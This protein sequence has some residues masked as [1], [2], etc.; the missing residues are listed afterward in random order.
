MAWGA[1]DSELSAEQPLG[2]CANEAGDW[3]CVASEQLRQMLCA[4][5]DA[6]VKISEHVAKQNEAHGN[7]V[8]E[9][10]DAMLRLAQHTP[11]AAER[12]RIDVVNKAMLYFVQAEAA[13]EEANGISVFAAHRPPQITCP[14]P[15]KGPEK[16]ACEHDVLA[17]AGRFRDLTKDRMALQTKL[18]AIQRDVQLGTRRLQCEQRCFNVW[19]LIN[20]QLRLN[21]ENG[22]IAPD[23][24][25]QRQVNAV[26]D[27]GVEEIEGTGKK[28]AGAEAG[29]TE[30][31]GQH[32]TQG[33]EKQ[34]MVVGRL[35]EWIAD[36]TE[37]LHVRCLVRV[38]EALE[39]EIKQIE[40]EEN[41]LEQLQNPFGNDE[42]HN[43]GG[44]VVKKG[45]EALDSEFAE[46][47]KNELCAITRRRAMCYE[48]CSAIKLYFTKY[49]EACNKPETSSKELGDENGRHIGS[50][51]VS[52]AAAHQ[53]RAARTSLLH[54]VEEIINQTQAKGGNT[55]NGQAGKGN[56][57]RVTLEQTAVAK[58][59]HQQ[60]F[61]Q[62]EV[63]HRSMTTLVMYSAAH[64]RCLKGAM[65]EGGNN[66]H[67]GKA[68]FV[69]GEVDSASEACVEYLQGVK[70]LL[71]R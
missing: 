69:S 55:R 31:S 25:E 8:I 45:H 32:T 61:Q 64:S 27:E 46:F 40:G 5:D 63:S 66:R 43:G 19:Q 60:Q 12:E 35:E 1:G 52:P 67:H 26:P 56:I 11:F 47:C 54:L 18:R 44:E 41:D 49:N 36:S 9:R 59:L 37:H 51:S 13:Y 6:L 33:D 28:R 70:T 29:A 10:G 2:E 24:L 58:Q 17:V 68:V 71:D 30:I 42:M 34:G 39:K 14:V 21:R 22:S 20:V 3:A 62:H 50:V 65:S 7:T 38:R 4:Q 48:A 16:D 15:L 57:G 23:H 53:V